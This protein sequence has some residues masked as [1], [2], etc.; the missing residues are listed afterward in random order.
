MFHAS[1]KNPNNSSRAI[2]TILLDEWQQQLVAQ[3]SF[4]G[5]HDHKKVFAEIRIAEQSFNLC[6]LDCNINWWL[7][8]LITGSGAF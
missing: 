5:K 8:N 3:S 6:R 7:Y 4:E 2:K 1:V